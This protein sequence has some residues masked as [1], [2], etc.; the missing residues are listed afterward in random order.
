MRTGLIVSKKSV[1]RKCF[2]NFIGKVSSTLHLSF[3]A[4]LRN[5]FLSLLSNF[6]LGT[7]TLCLQPTHL[8]RISIPIRIISIS[9]V[10]HGWGFFICTTSPS[11]YSFFSILV[12]LHLF[13]FNVSHDL[14]I[15]NFNPIRIQMLF[16]FS[17]QD[18]SHF[19]LCSSVYT[20][21]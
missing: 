10:P 3:R 16:N 17:I 12:P 5:I 20:P 1:S 8:I 4:L 15:R 7:R 19:T 6:V 13:L 14:R 2:T 11:W 9:L 18:P 21:R